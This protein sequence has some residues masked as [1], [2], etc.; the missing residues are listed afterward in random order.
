MKTAYKLFRVRKNGSIGSLFIDRRTYLP[1]GVWMQAQSWPTKGF[2]LRPGWHATEVPHAPHLSLKG[3]IWCEVDIEDYEVVI[4]PAMQGGIW[5]L[6]ER[7][8]IVGPVQ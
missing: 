3:R 4:R 1:L 8:M 6:A 2:A 7:M 5:Y